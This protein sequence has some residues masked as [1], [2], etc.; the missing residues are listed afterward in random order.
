M[1]AKQRASR[2]NRAAALSKGLSATETAAVSADLDDLTSAV[3]DDKGAVLARYR[4]PVGGT[5]VLVVSLPIDRVE[6]TPTSAIRR[7]RTSNG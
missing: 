6:P 2:R 7:T 1:A 3:E 5:P 4:D